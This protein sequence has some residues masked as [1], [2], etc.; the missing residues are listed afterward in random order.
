VSFRHGLLGNVDAAA[1]PQS[2]QVGPSATL[3][4]NVSMMCGYQ[5]DN[6]FWPGVN[7]DVS[8]MVTDAQS[9]AVATKS[10]SW[11]G[12]STYTGSWTPEVVKPNVHVNVAAPNTRRG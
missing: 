6:H 7:V 3:I 12:I 8:A 4:A 10:L 5:I 9:G 1:L 2:L 11:T